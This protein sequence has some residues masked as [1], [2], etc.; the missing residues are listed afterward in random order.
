MTSKAQNSAYTHS[1]IQYGSGRATNLIAGLK[2]GN[3]FA[4][5]HKLVTKG[6]AIV[7]ALGGDAY[8]NG[9]TGGLYSKGVDQAKSMGYGRKPA[10]RRR[11]KK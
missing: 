8:L 1:G 9:K 7:T 4:K 5:E 11:A 3:A 10:K 6:A 2:K